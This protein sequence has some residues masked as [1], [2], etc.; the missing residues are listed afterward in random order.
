MAS[1]RSSSESVGS[2]IIKRRKIFKDPLCVNT[3][4]DEY[5][6]LPQA[7]F[8]SDSE[9]ERGSQTTTDSENN[10]E[11]PLVDLT[12]Y[13]MFRYPKVARELDLEEIKSDRNYKFQDYNYVQNLPKGD[14]KRLDNESC[15]VCGLRRMYLRH[16]HDASL[17][18]KGIRVYAC[19]ACSI[20]CLKEL[21]RIVKTYYEEHPYEDY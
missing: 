18:V 16:A 21:N 15:A 1:K 5:E 19:T 3:A 11:T 7:D 9:S 6:H 12:P 10:D 4:P 14:P 2:G 20:K 13:S 17:Y 8:S